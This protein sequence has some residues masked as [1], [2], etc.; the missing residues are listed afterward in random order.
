MMLRAATPVHDTLVDCHDEK[1]IKLTCQRGIQ[2][3]SMSMSHPHC[4]LCSQEP[5]NPLEA[6]RPVHCTDLKS[7]AEGR[8]HDLGVSIFDPGGRVFV[9]LGFPQL[10]PVG[11]QDGSGVC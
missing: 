5:S 6:S 3:Y 7:G 10:V 8:H 1:G 11:P 4:L 2:L 9:A